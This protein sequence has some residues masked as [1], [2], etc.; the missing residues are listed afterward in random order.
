MNEQTIQAIG[1]WASQIRDTIVK[2]APAVW[3]TATKVKQADCIGALV[4]NGLEA[5]AF[6]VTAVVLAL[7]SAKLVKICTTFKVD[8]PAKPGSYGPDSDYNSLW[9][10]SPIPWLYIIGALGSAVCALVASCYAWSTFAAVAFD[11]WTW[12]GVTNPGLA[13]AHD[14]ILKALSQ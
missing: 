6:V 11:Q 5:V 8:P 3:H 10:H 1:Q 9:V 2:V 12:I 13:V 7:V 14:V 4:T